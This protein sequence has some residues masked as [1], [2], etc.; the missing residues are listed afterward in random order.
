MRAA[1][2]L[3]EAGRTAETTT[4]YQRAAEVGA[5]DAMKRAAAML[6]EAGRSEEAARLHQYG[7]EPGGRIA[8]PWTAS[9]TE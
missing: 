5:T 4:F 8:V 7:I 1:E 3:R 9:V 2:M 6:R